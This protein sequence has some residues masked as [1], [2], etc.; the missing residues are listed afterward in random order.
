MQPAEE[1][2]HEELIQVYSRYQRSQGFADELE[3]LSLLI[4]ESLRE[5]LDLEELESVQ[6]DDIDPEFVLAMTPHL[7]RWVPWG[8]RVKEA[9]ELDEQAY[10]AI[11]LEQRAD[12]EG[13]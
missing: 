12:E 10:Q 2:A 13:A 8:W 11:E 3:A 1:L 9:V 4:E 7:D 5:M 6:L